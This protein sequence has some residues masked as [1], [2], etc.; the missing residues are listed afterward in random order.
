MNKG[1]PFIVSA[2]SGAGKTTLVKMAVEHFPDMHF[3]VSYTTREPR[4]GEVDGVDYLFVDDRAFDEM[5]RKGDFIEY[6]EV[7][8]RRYGTLLKDLISELARGKDVL[9]DIDVQGAEQVRKILEYGVYI[10]IVPPSIE[11]C[12]KRLME[13]GKDSQEEIKKRVQV[14]INEIKRAENYDYIIINDELEGAFERLKSVI[15]AEKTR[16]QRLMDRV[17]ETFGI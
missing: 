7:H 8:G 14:S 2:P 15:T 10:F 17:K 5:A 13:R 12:E 6:A 4:Q 1:I 9:L 3:S 16:G 11:E